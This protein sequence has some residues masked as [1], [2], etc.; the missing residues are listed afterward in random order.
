M[1]TR[2]PAKGKSHLVD[3]PTN[4]SL[5][6]WV[7]AA[8]VA[9]TG[10][11]WAAHDLGPVWRLAAAAGGGYL[12]FKVATVGAHRVG[13]R[14]LSP[15]AKL[16]FAIPWPGF[17][18]G[19]F[20]ARLEDQSSWPRLVGGSTRLIVG[21]VVLSV[22][23]AGLEAWG[24]VATW[25]GIAGVL[26]VVHLGYAEILTWCVQKLGFGVRP[27]FDRP[28]ASRSLGEFW[29]RRWNVAFVEMDRALYLPLLRWRLK[30]RAAA[31]GVFVLSGVLHEMAISYP[32]G[33]GY[34]LPMT[35][36]GIHA[37]AVFAERSVL[38][39]RDWPAWLARI[40]TVSL[41]LVP[42]PLLFHEAFRTEL[43][44]PLLEMIEGVL[45]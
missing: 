25:L 13:F 32:A 22:A 8:V 31:F 23:A 7:G 26:L 33:A 40:W 14:R 2:S 43:I 18:E 34:G 12:L 44:V 21:L 5:A 45:S 35:Y 29:T 1:L 6:V 39:V 38:R 20:S 28:W 37:V 42:L 27:L 17:D 3:G 10:L 15:T 4:V 24:E 9:L 16:V 19:R 11:L 30:P 36:F 41:V